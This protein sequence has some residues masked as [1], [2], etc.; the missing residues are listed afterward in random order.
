MFCKNTS[1]QWQGMCGPCGGHTV[2]IP[3]QDTAEAVTAKALCTIRTVLDTLTD[4]QRVAVLAELRTQYSHV[5][6]V[7]EARTAP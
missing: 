4:S 6:V 2:S 3:D 1:T 7:G 5:Y